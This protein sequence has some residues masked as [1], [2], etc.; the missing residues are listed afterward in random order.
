MT[1][2]LELPAPLTQGRLVAIL[3]DMPFNT[4]IR[5]IDALAAAGVRS[6]EVT[7]SSPQA[8]R[9]IETAISNYPNLSVGA[10]TILTGNDLQNA[11][12][13]GAAFLL[14]PHVN[15]ELIAGAV[16]LGIPFIP[17]A[18]TATECVAGMAAGASAIKLFPAATGGP[19]HLAA[20]RQPLPRLPFI[21]TGGVTPDNASDYFAAGA[22]AVALGSSLTSLE[23]E[24]L[25]SAVEKLMR[26]ATA[27]SW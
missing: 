24:E 11:A 18:F 12:S 3:R 9:T 6:V 25:I 8:V 17:G 21:P 5:R 23:D 15:V 27:T 4:A 19:A 2:P 26:A 20:L 13:A 10:G 16:D 7:M 22:A 1:R 14:S